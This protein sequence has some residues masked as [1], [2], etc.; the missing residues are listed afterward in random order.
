MFSGIG[1]LRKNLICKGH[2]PI[3]GPGMQ[4]QQQPNPQVIKHDI[5]SSPFDE[6]LKARAPP[7]HRHPPPRHPSPAPLQ[8]PIVGPV[9]N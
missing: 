9:L 5:V 2:V 8:I 3:P 1:I 7:R 4:P 6:A